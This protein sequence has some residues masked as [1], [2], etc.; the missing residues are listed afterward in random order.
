[1]PVPPVASADGQVRGAP[2]A[3]RDTRTREAIAGVADLFDA[4]ALTSAWE[5]ALAA[6]AYPGPPRLLH[7]DLLWGNLLARDQR[8]HAVIDWGCLAKGDPS[9]DLLPAWWLFD[10]RPGR[11]SLRPPKPSPT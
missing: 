1:M 2:L 7:G 8:L 5:D 3:C 10:A 9:P 11:S 4:G 6:P